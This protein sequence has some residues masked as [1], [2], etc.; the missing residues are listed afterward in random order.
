MVA[1]VRLTDE[2]KKELLAEF[3]ELEDRNFAEGLSYDEIERINYLHERIY[4]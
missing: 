3:F 2:D 4:E 1:I